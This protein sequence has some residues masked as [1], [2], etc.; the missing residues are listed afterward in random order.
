MKSNTTIPLGAIVMLKKVENHFGLFHGLFND[1]KGKAKDFIPLTKLLT[2]NKLT[3]SVSINQINNTYPLEFI[4]QLRMNDVPS[5]RSMYRTLERVGKSFPLILDRYQQLIKKY[6][7]VD[8]KHIIDFSSTYFEGTKSELAHLGYSRDKLPGKLQITFGISTGLTGIPSAITIQKGN[9]QDKKHMKLMIEIVSKVLPEGSLLIFDT[10]ANTKKNKQRIRGHKFHYLTLRAK[11]VGP[12]KKYLTFFNSR[13]EKGNITHR[14]VNNRRYSCVKKKEGEKTSYIY[15]CPELYLDQ[16]K[17]KDRKFERQKEKGNKV[18]KKRK[19]QVL[20]SEQG[21]VRLLPSLQ[22]TLTGIVNPYITGVEGFFILESSVDKDL[23][24]IL[25]LYKQRDKA[26]KFFR[27]LKEGIEL[28]PLRHWN[29]WSVIGIFFI[30]FLANLLINLIHIL[31]KI[32]PV[33]NVKLLKK[34]LINL[35]LTYVYPK[36]RFRFTVLSNVSPEILELFG[37]FVWKYRD[38]TLDLRW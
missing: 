21:W 31:N 1:V 16:I 22:K 11:K 38:K 14:V 8:R 35:T 19:H 25:K 36:N 26:K 37:D 9:V 30:S 3:H 5:N 2:C 27:A 29:K 15:F 28:R 24:K 23:W 10:G 4:Q 13:L 17:A 32:S 34:H 33:K 18:L 20:P 6:K 7:L 12:Y